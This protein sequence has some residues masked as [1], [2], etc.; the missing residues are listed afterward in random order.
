MIERF[1]G[2]GV[3]M[4]KKKRPLKC[5]ECGT[6]KKAD[7]VRRNCITWTAWGRNSFDFNWSRNRTR[8]DLCGNCENGKW[9]MCSNCFALIDSYDYGRGYLPEDHDGESICPGCAKKKGFAIT[10]G[11]PEGF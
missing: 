7:E 6:T 4:P 5:M 10:V 3:E 9:I 11:M 8:V 1:V 2:P